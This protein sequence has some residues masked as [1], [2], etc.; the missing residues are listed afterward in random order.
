ME[1]SIVLREYPPATDAAPAPQADYLACCNDTL[2]AKPVRIRTDEHGF[3]VT[4]G[5]LDADLPCVLVLGDSVV[6]NYWIDEHC[7]ACAVLESILL[8]QGYAYRVLNGGTTGV[9]SLHAYNIYINKGIPL[10][11]AALI[12]MTG[13]IDAMSEVSGRSLWKDALK[14][15]SEVRYS[16][17]AHLERDAVRRLFLSACRALNVP[18]IFTTIGYAPSA[19]TCYG[20]RLTPNADMLWPAAMD[21]LNDKTRAFAVQNRSDLID[22]ALDMDGREDLFYDGLHANVAGCALIADKM[23]QALMKILPAR[24]RHFHLG[25]MLFSCL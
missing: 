18:L 21:A 19:S 1:R 16:Q 6:E 23:A 17:E 13:A 9:N 20:M 24:Y 11:P 8:S 14:P 25:V 5:S 7:R 15:S 3:I 10:R 4:G 22:L 12:L 2:S